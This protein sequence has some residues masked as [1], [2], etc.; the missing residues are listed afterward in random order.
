MIERRKPNQSI[1]DTVNKS[2]P[3]QTAHC[4]ALEGTGSVSTPDPYA[5]DALTYPNAADPPH[6]SPLLRFPVVN[7]HC[8]DLPAAAEYYGSR[9]FC[10]GCQGSAEAHTWRC[11]SCGCLAF[12]PHREPNVA[13]DERGLWEQFAII[14]GKHHLRL[15]ESARL[16]ALCES[17][18][19][20]FL[21]RCM[22]G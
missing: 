7:S 6:L 21:V 13:S 19:V 1:T 16:R 17:L 20:N 2:I 4:R 22:S 14:R 18:V 3:Q 5:S 8:S 15:D 11:R 9:V 10:A 12:Q